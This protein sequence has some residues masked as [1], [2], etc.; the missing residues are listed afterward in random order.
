MEVV[1]RPNLAYVPALDGIRA[2][3][4]LFVFLYHMGNL[5]GGWVGVDIFFTLS[6]YLITLI[7]LTEYEARGS[8]L[9]GQFFF[10]ESAGFS[11]QSSFSFPSR[12]RSLSILMTTSAMSRWTRSLRFFMSKIFAAHSGR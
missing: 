10:G 5:R 1:N 6:G 2:V 8:I 11:R 3:A 4:I 9:I 7:L 12:W